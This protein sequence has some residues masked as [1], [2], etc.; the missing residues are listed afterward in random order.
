VVAGV[1]LVLVYGVAAGVR[2]A[3]RRHGDA[4]R[5][6]VGRLGNA[7]P[8]PALRKLRSVVVHV[9]YLDLDLCN[10]ARRID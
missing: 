7:L 4:A 1:D 6:R 5:L 10:A 3:G 9:Q 2:V 8:Q